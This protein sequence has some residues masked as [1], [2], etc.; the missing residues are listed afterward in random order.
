MIDRDFV[1]ET[2][3]TRMPHE[4]HERIFN[5]IVRW[6]RFGN[7]FHFDEEPQQVFRTH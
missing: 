1:L 5:T 7:L 3:A 2:L 6:S 4:N